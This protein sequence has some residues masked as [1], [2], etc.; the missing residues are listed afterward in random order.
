MWRLF[1]SAAFCLLGSA[2]CAADPVD[3][4]ARAQMSR[5]HIPAMAIVVVRDGT[6]EKMAAYG[7]ADLDWDAPASPRTAF[8]LASGTKAFTGTLLM[9]LVE[10]GKLGLDDPVSRHLPD[11][12]DAWKAITVRH[13]AAHT[14]GLQRDPSGG[15]PLASVDAAVAAAYALPL[16]YETGARSQYGLTDFVVLTKIMEKVSGLGFVELLRDQIVRPLGMEDTVFDDAVDEG[17]RRS[18]LPV[19]H[20]ATTY[21][22][23]GGTQ[24]AYQFY[25]PKY[26]YSAGGLFSS[27][28]DIAKLLIALAPGR[29][30]KPATLDAMWAPVPLNGGGQGEFAVGWGQGRYRGLRAVGHSGGPA[31]SDLL[32]FP[33]QKLGVAVLTN[34]GALFPVLAELVADI[35]L[36]ESAGPQ[37]PEVADTDPQVTERLRQVVSAMRDGTIR[38]EDYAPEARER[39]IPTVR[40]FGLP[41]VHQLDPL[42]GFRLIGRKPEA[43][44]TEYTYRAV[45]GR[46]P[47]KWRFVLDKEGRIAD[48]EPNSR[49]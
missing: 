24:R 18:W 25:Y 28:A 19:N 6:I 14:S 33:D 31:L 40:D 2:L 48:L 16:E 36:P 46:H 17:D 29:L 13:L 42:S 41:L 4:F 30:L 47:M 12:P 37:D 8:Q 43:E 20:R 1:R 21:R 44:R 3:D 32:Y 38:E 15:K 45:F 7:I 10:Q 35:Y 27:A 39:L 5:G 26:T 23:S 11:A 49:D 34:Q 22:W 9:K